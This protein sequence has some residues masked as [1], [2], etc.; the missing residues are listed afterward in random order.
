MARFPTLALA[1]KRPNWRPFPRA[2]E[3]PSSGRMKMSR[4]G[5]LVEDPRIR[6]PGG[7]SNRADANALS[8]LFRNKSQEPARIVVQDSVDC[9]FGYARLDQLRRE[10]GLGP[11]VQRTC[12]RAGP[13]EIGCQ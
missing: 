8:A 2:L 6:L 11:S 5:S 7:K 10:D 4:H 13:R 12:H 3:A 9:F 1:S